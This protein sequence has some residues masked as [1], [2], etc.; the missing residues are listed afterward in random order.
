MIVKRGIG[1]LLRPMLEF[2][3]PPACSA[4]GGSPEEGEWLCAGCRGAVRRAGPPDPVYLR[5]RARLCAAGPAEEFL[6]LWWFDSDGPVQ[7]LL[8]VLKYEGVRRV[9]RHLGMEMAGAFAVTLRGLGVDG[10]VVVPLH[11][12]KHRERGY[13]QSLLIAEGLAEGLGRP[14]LH[15]VLRR[16]RYTKSQTTLSHDERRRNVAG[17]F[18]LEPSCRVPLGGRTLLLVDDVAT[19]GSTLGAC[20][21]VLRARGAERV[22]VCTAALAR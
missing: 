5:A 11:R 8:H 17:A 9:G 18:A 12:A 3:F 15:P 6:A 22:V 21:E 20:A 4:C 10:I 1:T 14:L 2:V 13:N 19:T 16:I 7:R